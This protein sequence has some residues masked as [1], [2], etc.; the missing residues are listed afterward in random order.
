MPTRRLPLPPQ[1]ALD[2][3]GASPRR[4]FFHLLSLC[5]VPTSGHD[6]AAAERERDRLAYFGTAEGREDLYRWVEGSRPHSVTKTSNTVTGG[7]L[8]RGDPSEE[9]TPSD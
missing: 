2:V 3:S 6:A 4:H 7:V 5:C 1:G 9:S 8:W